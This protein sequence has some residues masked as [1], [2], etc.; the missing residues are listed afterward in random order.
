MCNKN[1]WLCK[2]HEVDVWMVEVVQRSDILSI[3]SLLVCHV[4]KL[5]LAPSYWAR[6]RKRG[7]SIL[8]SYE[9]SN[10]NNG[11]KCRKSRVSSIFSFIFCFSEAIEGSLRARVFSCWTDIVYWIWEFTYWSASWHPGTRTFFFSSAA[12]CR[13]LFNLSSIPFAI[14]NSPFIFSFFFFFA[15][16]L[17]TVLFKSSNVWE[18]YPIRFVFFTSVLFSSSLFFLSINICKQ[19]LRYRIF[20]RRSMK[21]SYAD[22]LQFDR[23]SLAANFHHKT[24]NSIADSGSDTPL[25]LG[26]R[27]KGLLASTY[28]FIIA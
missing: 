2:K 4:C 5:L 15:I 20:L 8:L 26:Y 6:N 17:L 12:Q 22:K 19:S 11:S 27:N 13:T 28:V 18:V 14:H 24:G 7:S 1:E 3:S 21:L 9:Y 10:F 23:G 16:R 25:L